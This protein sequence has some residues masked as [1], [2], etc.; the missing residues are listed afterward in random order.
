MKADELRAQMKKDLEK[1]NCITFDLQQVQ[2][3][4]FLRENKSFYH[5]KTWLYDLGIHDGFGKKA[6]LYI[7]TEDVA[8]R[9]SR[10]IASCLYHYL[11]S[12]LTEPIDTLLSWS[13][14]C[15][16]QN[17]NFPMACFW[18]RI[19]AEFDV[20]D[21]IHRFPLSG[22]SYLPND[23]DFG[24]IEKAKKKKDSIY[25][26]EQYKDVMKSSKKTKPVVVEMKCNDF[27]DFQQGVHFSNLAKPI[28][29]EGNKFTWLKIQEFKFEKDLLGFKFRYNLDEPYRLCKFDSKR[30]FR[31]KKQSLFTEAPLL[32]P[33]YLKTLM[34]FVPLVYQKF[35]LDIIDDHADEI[36]KYRDAKKKGEKCLPSKAESRK[37]SEKGRR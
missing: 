15:G 33:H 17:R 26:V 3:L 30:S 8:S 2:P 24:D 16:G 9:G 21:I 19:L 4:P 12:Q 20:N 27:L 25:T 28:D 36:L 14:A 7:W 1:P 6:Y 18:L 10:E 35:Y 32:H 11:Q 22:H 29:S 5:R 37:T 34:Q 31:S 23:R 13:D